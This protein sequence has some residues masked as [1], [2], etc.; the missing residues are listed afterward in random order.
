MEKHVPKKPRHKNRNIVTAYDLVENKFVK[1]QKETFINNKQRY[2]G[3][4]SKRIPKG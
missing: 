2:C 3:T 1:I 4:T